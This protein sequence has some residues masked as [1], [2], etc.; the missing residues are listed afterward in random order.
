[1]PGREKRKQDRFPLVVPVKLTMRNG[2]GPAVLQM[3]TRDISSAG[4]FLEG[5]GSIYVGALVRVE[6]LLTV[7]GLLDVIQADSGARVQVTGRVIRST[8]DGFAVEF[9]RRYKIQPM[10]EGGDS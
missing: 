4:A 7:Q 10:K 8:K 5:H 2:N 9:S 3:R 6:L 1:M